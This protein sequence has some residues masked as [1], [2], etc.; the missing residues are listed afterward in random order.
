M[1]RYREQVESGLSRHCA[2]VYFKT[3]YLGCSERHFRKIPKRLR[4]WRHHLHVWNTARRIP[5]QDFDVIHLLDGSFGYVI[6]CLRNVATVATVHDIIPR[7]QMDGHFPSAPSI[8][9]GAKWIIQRGLKGLGSSTM[10]AADSE[11]TAMDLKKAGVNPTRGIVVAP[12]AIETELF[13]NPTRTNVDANARPY[14]FHIGNNGFYK[15]RIGAIQILKTMKSE[16]DLVMAGPPPIDSLLQAVDG[17]GLK[18]RIRFEVF[19]DQS[20]LVSLY[21]HASSLVFPSLYE[22]FGWPPLEAMALGCPVV[23]SDAGSLPEVVGNAGVVTSSEN[24]EQM[25]QACDRIMSNPGYR[26]SLVE[27]G[28]AHVKNFT[29]KQLAR[30]M[31]DCYR[32]AV[33]AKHGQ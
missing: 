27:R 6:D 20:H 28:K 15:N 22:G 21:K 13:S 24:Y 11:S 30:K 19:P 3:F 10:I 8:G 4:M 31:Q 7:L 14:I 32:C 1:G 5:V 2:S 23:S 29:L 18:D 17:S 12:L 25:G 16:V 26:Q 9:R 33:G